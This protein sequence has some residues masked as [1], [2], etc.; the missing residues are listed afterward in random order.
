M[1][2]I[3]RRML[4]AMIHHKVSREEVAGWL[5]YS[6]PG[7][8][9]GKLMTLDKGGR[10]AVIGDLVKNIEDTII[11]RKID[12]VAI[13]P[14]VKAHSVPE[15]ENSLIDEVAQILTD[16]AIKHN[17]SID[18]PH[19]VAKGAPDPGNADRGR[20]ASSRNDAFRLVHT[21][22]PMSVEEAKL[23]GIAEE[24]RKQYVREDNG[25]V[26]VTKGGGKPK[27]FRL[28]GVR[29]GN[30]TELYPNGDEV[31]TTEAWKPPELWA[32][33]STAELN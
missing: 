17:I 2:E 11:R 7:A 13:D 22:A 14:F 29:I 18:F 31:Q 19:H 27:W 16:L 9:A 10:G 5:F 4:A 30:G 32:D 23:F 8:A 3:K 33:V 1:K 15:N 28:V 12:L 20:G 6:S 25:K 21:L 24:D 26:N